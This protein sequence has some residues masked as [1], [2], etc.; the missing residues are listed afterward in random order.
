MNSHVQPE[1][2]AKPGIKTGTQFL[3]S[4]RDGREVWY[5]G[6]RLEDV[7][8]FPAFQGVLKTLARLYDKQNTPE[9]IDVMT[10]DTGEGYRASK[11]YLLPTTREK[12][13][14]RRQNHE[15]W[16]ADTFGQMGRNPDFCGGITIGLMEVRSDLAKLDPVFATN[17]ENYLKHCQRND[18]CLTHGLHDPN[19][20]KTLRPKQDPDRCVRI[21]RKTDEGYIVRGARYATLGPFANEI[22]VYPS[23]MLA[24]DEDEFAIWFALPMNTKGIRTVCRDSYAA[25]RNEEDF[26]L[27][28]RFD[29]QDALVIFDDVLVPFDRVFLAGHAKEAVRIYRAGLMRWAGYGSAVH[30][31]KRYDLFVGVGHLLAATGGTANRPRVQEELGE[32]VTLAETHAQLFHAAEAAATQSKSGYWGPGGHMTNRVLAIMISERMVS[33]IEHLGTGAMIFNNSSEDFEV[34]E[35]RPMLELYGRGHQTSARDRQRLVRLAFELTGDAFGSR[36]QMY[37]RLHSG[38]PYIWTANAWR[39]YD[40]S[41]GVETVNRLLGTHF[42]A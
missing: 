25:G 30:V 7:T 41:E 3:A 14:E 15:I 1:A 32:L 9:F 12:L 5:K 35:L 40:K 21:I 31:M 33:L 38:D 28:A 22:L 17:I 34:E 8:A 6:K 16:G 20:D 10:Y 39:T 2:G 18:L 11:S 36:Q 4:L 42:K 37:E 29:E 13:I 24:D 27:S 26:P 19:M 23:F